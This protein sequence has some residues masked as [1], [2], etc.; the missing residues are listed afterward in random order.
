MTSGLRVTPASVLL[1]RLEYLSRTVGEWKKSSLGKAPFVPLW[2]VV[3][4]NRT[5]LE[6]RAGRLF[7]SM[8]I[9]RANKVC[10]SLLNSDLGARGEFDLIWL[11]L[12]R[13]LVLCAYSTLSR[14]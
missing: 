14:R 2:S 7:Y 1:K 12:L 4:A 5:L 3:L 6:L 10:R 9:S 11:Q 8:A 13:S